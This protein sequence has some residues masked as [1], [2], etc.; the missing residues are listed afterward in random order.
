MS[1]L[2]S[3]KMIERWKNPGYR[4]QM[5]DAHL[6]HIPTNLF[7]LKENSIKTHG[8]RDKQLGSIPWNKGKKMPEITGEKH[9]LWVKDRSLLK[10]DHRD[11]NGQ[12]HKE[13]SKQV[14]NRDGWKCR[15]SNGNCS[16]HV[17]AHHILSW[18]DYPELHYEINNG[19]TLCQVHHPRKREQEAKLSP[20]FQSLVVEM[21]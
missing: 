12:L 1:N 5:S 21:Q 18:R 6:G 7:Q 15:I 13:W 16:G 3:E 2:Q 19:I 9:Y 20:F 10:D 14:K 4:K 8:N 17:V 11:R